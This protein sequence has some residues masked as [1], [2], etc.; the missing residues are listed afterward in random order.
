[1]GLLGVGKVA[2]AKEL[3][4]Q[5]KQ[6]FTRML[7]SGMRLKPVCRNTGEG[8]LNPVLFDKAMKLDGRVIFYENDI[9]A[10]LK[11]KCCTHLL[12]YSTC[13]IIK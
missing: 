4:G 3:V 10:N 12:Y 9:F 5:M 1:M 13:F 2:E 7:V 11:R 6:R 8:H